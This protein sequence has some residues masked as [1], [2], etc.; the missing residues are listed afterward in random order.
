[1]A[2]PYVNPVV[3]RQALP[4]FAPGRLLFVDST[5][6]SN[7]Y[8]GW[9][10][11]QPLKSITWALAK[12]ND[13]HGDVIVVFDG[14]DNDDIDTDTNGDDT[15]IT[16]NKDGVSIVSAGKNVIVKGIA[17]NDSVFKID[18]DRVRISALPGCWWT[19]QDAKAGDAGTIVEIA[20]G[21]VDAEVAFMR[22][23]PG[24]DADGYDEL[25]TINATAHGA[26][27]HDCFFVGNT[28][29]TDEGIVIGGTTADVRIEDNVFIDCCASAG[30]IVSA[31]VHT[32]CRIIGNTIVA[33]V[34]SKKGIVF[35]DNATGMIDKNTIALEDTDANGIDPGACGIGINYVNDGHATSAFVSPVAG[36]IT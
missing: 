26:Y 10:P 27:V 25:I 29:D 23:E 36:T 11:A 9:N 5:Y 33:N 18:A 30:T 6:G 1:M 24:A 28:T 17:A 3:I 21:A 34:G 22:T 4:F 20:A 7:S 12:C 2:R 19:V 8:E 32:N 31:A 35:T 15:P 13:D 14:Y 16:I